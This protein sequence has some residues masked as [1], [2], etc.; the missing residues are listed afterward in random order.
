MPNIIQKFRQ[1][2]IVFEKPGVLSEKNENLDHLQLPLTFGVLDVSHL[3]MST[4]RC[5][6]FFCFA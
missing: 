5:S 6:G 3:P 1:T 4:K 2:I